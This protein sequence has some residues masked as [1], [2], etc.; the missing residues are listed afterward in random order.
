MDVLT[1][2]E[3][4]RADRLTIAAG[5]PGFALMMSAGQAVA[6]AAMELVE[7]GPIVVVAGRGNN[8]GDGFVAAAELA[9]RGRDVSVILLCERDSL[10]GD[11]ALAAKGWK[12]PVLPFNPQALGKPALIIDALFGAGLN[13]P[14]KGD[15][16]EMIAAINAN[17]TPVL[18]V[19]LP[20]GIN[21]TSGAVMGAAVQATETVTFF[22]KKPAH[23]LL[24]GRMYCGRVRVADIGIAA[25]V[26][27]E[28]KP[29]TAENLPQVWRW[30]FPVPRIDGHKYA[31]GHAVVVSGDIAS[32]GAARLAARAA[33]RAGAGL[34]TLASPRDALAVNAAALTAVMVRAV[35]NPIQFAELLDDKRLNACVIGPG[36]GVS[37]R[38]RDFVHTAL[39]AQR[40]LVLDADALTSFAG[41]PDRLFEAIKASDGLG[42]VLTPHEGEFPRLFSDISNKHPG[43]SKL[44]RVRAAAER[45]G[46]VVLLKGADTVIASPDGRAT[47]AAN[48]PPWLA[49][50]GAGDVLA[51]IIAGFLAQGVAAFEAASIGV[52]L[53]GEGAS[54][55]GPGLIAEDLTEVLPSVFRRLYD[56]FGIEY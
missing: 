43:R 41:T 33:L 39:S 17:G 8:G 15:P 11:A 38:T 6:E 7:E 26:L 34:V 1:T 10:H 35:D 5:T 29:L 53:H 20:S 46:A 12:Y 27:D 2:T 51:G 24:P 32:T 4:E 54:E 30:S 50:A 3:M 18:A 47:I 44:E 52:W 48:A 23:L 9:A 28:I 36:A 13:R 45:S 31:R 40:H 19:D 55:A 21:G 42:V 14:V 22:R 37:A 56:E 25:Q 16:L 49:T